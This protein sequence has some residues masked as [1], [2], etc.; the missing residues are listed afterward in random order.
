MNCAPYRKYSVIVKEEVARTRN[1]Y[2]FPNLKIPRTTAQYW[3]RRER[4]TRRPS[5]EEIESLYRKKSEFLLLELEKEKSLRQLV[6]EIRRIF[7]FDFQFKHLKSKTERAK[8]LAAIHECMKHHQLS[9][10][11]RA[12]GLPKSAYQRWLSEISFCKRTRGLCARRKAM[13]LTDLE[14]ATMKRFVT[15]KQYAHISVASLHLL[16]Q[17]RGELFC[18]IDTW[19]KYIRC[20]EW[21]R[22]WRVKKFKIRKEGVRAGRPNEIWHIDVSVV[23]IRPGFKLY[24]QA[25]IDNFSRFVLAWRVT[26]TIGAVETIETL[27]QAKENASNFLGICEDTNIFMDPGTENRNRKVQTYITSVNLTR[28]LARVE[29]SYSNSMI[30]GLFRQ[31]KNNFL[32]HQGIR[33]IEDLRRKVAF[34]LKQHNEVIPRASQS[35]GVPKEVFISSWGASQ[36]ELLEE[37]KIR[38]HLF[39]RKNNL[40]PSCG[41]CPG[42]SDL[43]N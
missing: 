33:S 39:R 20:Y 28:T 36:I 37:R 15:G 40:A 10:C 22:P 9:R 18:A 19:Y 42:T 7:P 13:Q 2:L 17:R 1:V 21:K 27:K 31:L 5:R 6:E 41:V 4:L 25:V 14:L 8:V 30:E 38:A 11:L 29:V 3:V 32:Y 26:E 24:I 12:I 34:Y 23:N 16:A 35:G 43:R